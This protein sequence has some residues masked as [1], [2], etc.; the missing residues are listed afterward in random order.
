MDIYKFK[1]LENG[2]ILLEKI[3]INPAEYKIEDQDNG[4]KILRKVTIIKNMD[5]IAKYDFKNSN[6]LSCKLNTEICDK[7]KYNTILTT[8]YKI[9]NDGVKIIK[10]TTLNI[11]TIAKSDKGFFYIPSLGISI[12]HCEANKCL[13]EII[14]QCVNNNISIS[15]KI[16][17]LNKVVVNVIL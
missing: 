5:D 2:D 9:I 17:L 3:T 14:N 16:K 4:N 1:D 15:I 7:L 8:V 10:N 12:Q 11:K 6:I 13:S